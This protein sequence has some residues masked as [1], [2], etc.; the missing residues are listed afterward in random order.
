MSTLLTTAERSRE[1]PARSRGFH[2][3]RGH[4]RRARPIP[5]RPRPRVADLELHTLAPGAPDGRRDGRAGG[6]LPRR[7]AQLARPRALRRAPAGRARATSWRT[8]CATPRRAAWRCGSPTTP[9]TT[10][11]SSR[12]RRAREPE[13]IEALAVPHRGI[14]GIPDLMHHKYV[15]R[16]GEAVWTG[17][18]NWT[19]DSWTL[20]E[21]VV[22]VTRLGRARGRVRAQ[23]RG[24]LED[25][26]RR[27]AP[28][29]PSRARWSVGG[30][31]VRAWFTPGP[32]RGALAPDR[33][34]DRARRGGACGS[35]RR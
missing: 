34:G 28:A 15:V 24:A 35:P 25:A 5:R 1:R 11:A 10:S 4:R 20:Q 32:R 14:P 19:I 12:R 8:R 26:R 2:R 6:G 17:S 7:G 33:R 31:Q 27:A 16:D 22:I 30:H 21:N 23:L 18:T 9:T 13:L 3:P 29:A